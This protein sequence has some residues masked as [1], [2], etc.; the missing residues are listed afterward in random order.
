MKKRDRKKRND[1]VILFPDLEKRL[2]DKGLESLQ[3]K[4]FQE[5]IEWLEQAISLNDE[6]GDIYIGL[7]LAY[8]ESGELI[9]AK[10]L[11]NT[12]LQKGIGDYI[13]II[14]LYLMILVQLHQYDEIVRTIEILL[15]EKEIPG[16]KID[17]FTRMLQ[18]S[19]RMAV[20][21]PEIQ[22]ED[23]KEI[24]PFEKELDLF[25]IND[26]HGQIL[27]A[28][29]L[30]EINIRPY[31]RE[32]KAYLQSEEGQPFFQTMLLNVL[33]DHEFEK[34][35]TITKFGEQISVLPSSLQAV[36]DNKQLEKLLEIIRD[37]VEHVDPILYEH[38]KSLVERHFFLLYPFGLK[39]F[40]EEVW[41]ASYHHLASLYQG[42][43]TS[44]Y[45]L[46]SLYKVNIKDIELAGQFLKEI[47]EI[48]SSI[49]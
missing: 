2:L 49:F 1:K 35:V 3:K 28:A 4:R 44:L 19:R 34:E 48:S 47:E 31:M 8:F 16:D 26:Q 40:N 38:I 12:M 21:T 13:Q 9:K 36:Q 23:E 30:S 42:G 37:Q 43:E 33:R 5:A 27:M 14:D 17:H 7:V 32:L 29:K 10:E 22:H 41:G 20:S 46:A 24:D 11:A 6:D 15:E 45:E 39:S 25:S 18:F